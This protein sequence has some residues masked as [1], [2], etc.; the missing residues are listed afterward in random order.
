MSKVLMSN[1][2]NT[3]PFIRPIPQGGGTSIAWY[4]NSLK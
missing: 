2:N 3:L 1:P 4:T